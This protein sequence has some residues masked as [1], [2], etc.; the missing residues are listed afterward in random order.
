MQQSLLQ[1]IYKRVFL[2][3]CLLLMLPGIAIHASPLAVQSITLGQGSHD[4]IVKEQARSVYAIL[5][6]ESPSSGLAI[7]YR[8]RESVQDISLRAAHS[9]S[10]TLDLVSYLHSS[11]GT[12]DAVLSDLVVGYEQG[13]SIKGLSLSYAY[14]D[15]FKLALYSSTST[16]FEYA[17][18]SISPIVGSELSFTI[19]D[20]FEAGAGCFP[21]NG[22]A[23]LGNH[24]V[25]ADGRH[26]QC[27]FRKSSIGQPDG[28]S[29]RRSQ[30]QDFLW[31]CSTLWWS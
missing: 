27:K 7:G 2:L 1:P 17:C 12:A 22:H 8:N 18:Q 24:D 19:G 21:M 29:S 10:D 26:R 25:R 15:R 5:Q 14:Q 13:I 3:L 30:S 23:V 28:C 4:S 20:E 31:P 9:L 6:L 11:L 16:F